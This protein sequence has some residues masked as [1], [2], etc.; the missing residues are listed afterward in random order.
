MKRTKRV[1]E[2]MV[3]IAAACC[4]FDAVPSRAAAAPP[5]GVEVY[6]YFEPEVSAADMNGEMVQMYSNKLR[7]DLQAKLSERV[8]FQGNFDYI[9]YSGRTSYYLTDYL[10]DAVKASLPP[11]ARELY[12]LEFADRDFLDNA[13]IRISFDHLDLSIG[14]IQI[15]PGTGYAWN[16]T[17]M[18]NIK[19]I[20]DPT[21]EKPGHD[22]VKAD[23]PLGTLG[24]AA[25]LYEPGD[26]LEHS[27]KFARIKMHAGHFD[28][29]LAGGER[30]VPLSDHISGVMTEE[31]RRLAGGD[32]AGQLFD[33]GVWGEFAY[34]WM[35]GSEDY[36]EGLLGADYTFESGLYILNEFYLNGRG[37]KD[38]RD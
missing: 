2:H 34:N 12:V 27:G 8:S 21:Y 36:F 10:A 28:L 7:I 6:G 15:S 29:S 16:P 22:A 26:D 31:R 23:I 33:L 11:E 18:Y 37:E 30:F 13:F 5:E 35:A 3:L 19:D 1:S 24:T 20:L 4:I 17:D 32:F 25:L 38:W 9:T 14:R